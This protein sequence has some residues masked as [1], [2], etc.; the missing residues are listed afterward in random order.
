M[1]QDQKSLPQATNNTPPSD[2]WLKVRHWLTAILITGGVVSGG[3]LIVSLQARDIES[4]QQYE[5]LQLGSTLRAR[6]MRELNGVLYL[7]SGL[8]SYLT[9]RHSQ[10]QRDEVEAILAGLYRDS[11]HVRNFGIAV[12]HTLT[13][14]HP[15][16]GNEKA[17]GLYYPNSPAQWRDVQRAIAREQPLLVGPLKLV[18]GGNGLIYRVPIFIKGKYWGLVSTVIDSDSMLRSALS[19]NKPEDHTVA[20]RG[21]NGEGMLGDVFWGDAGLFGKPDTQL[22]DIDVPGGKWALAL[23]GN[24]QRQQ[25]VLKV[26]YLLVWFLGLMLGWFAYTVLTQRSNLARL[27][28]YDAL[29]GLPNRVLVQDRVD[30]AMSA[31]RRDQ[32]RAY[33]LMF[34]D[35]DGFKQ[36][37]DQMGHKAGDIVLQQVAQR[38]AKAVR[39][40]D[41]VSRWGGDEFI[42]FMEHVDP[43]MAGTIIEKIRT[44]VETPVNI[45][46]RTAQVGASIG[47]AVA[48]ADG[49]NLTALARAADER[50][51]AEKRKRKS[52]DGV[53]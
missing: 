36:I 22:I 45:G 33:L 6:L 46:D 1:T 9:V 11:R 44:A 2:F 10:M 30:H 5:L 32:Q 52:G 17:I 34:V 7:T 24:T 15:I 16:Q 42:V 39:D 43:E 48:P 12:G 20:I 28:L 29:T 26:I 47:T 51:Y 35:L 41:T 14:I 50:M 21:R 23:R 49:T 53:L 18:Q 31:L 4:R 37:N 38:I 40:T 19:E 25:A 13:Y 8:N 27:A 3:D